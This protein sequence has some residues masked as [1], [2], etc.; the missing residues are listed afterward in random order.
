MP[1][2]GPIFSRMSHGHEG[3]VQQRIANLNHCIESL[4]TKISGISA[5]CRLPLKAVRHRRSR[6]SFAQHIQFLAFAEPASPRIPLQTQPASLRSPQPHR[7]PTLVASDFPVRTRQPADLSK[8]AC[9]NGPETNKVS[10]F[11]RSMLPKPVSMGKHRF[12]NRFVAFVDVLGFRNLVER[13]SHEDRIFATVRDA[14]KVLDRQALGFQQYRRERRSKRQELR[15]KG[16]VSVVGETNLQMTAFSDCFVLSEVSPAWH[17]LAAVQSLGARFL[18]EGILTRGAVVLGKAY[19]N[20][21]VLFGPGIIEAYELES[22]VAKYP[23]ILVTDAVREAVWGY[24]EGLWK[25]R[26]L[27]RDADGCWY[28]NL[29]VPS[30]SS[31]AP[32]SGPDS[33]TDTRAHLKQVHR[34]LTA[35]WQSAQGNTE[36]MSKVWWLIHQFNKVAEKDGLEPIKRR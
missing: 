15:R 7:D 31:W 33:P 29:L 23:R 27:T 24:H 21:R 32:L 11:V 22:R 17:V 2:W 14:L 26:L 18:A 1:V 6:L 3:E 30:F 19:H 20:G 5:S 35:A 12:Q 9:L 36:N 8:P 10:L 4:Q 16:G 25:S 34:S 13:M 28:V